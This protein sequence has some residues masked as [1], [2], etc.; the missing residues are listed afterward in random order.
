MATD[1]CMPPIWQD[2]NTD[3]K[4]YVFFKRFLPE[5]LFHRLLS[6]AHKNSMLEYPNGQPVLYRDAAMFWMRPS[7]DYK[8]A[9]RL[10]ILKEEGMIEVTISSSKYGMKPSD[11]LTQVFSM[12]DGIHKRDFPFVKFHCGPA[13]ISPECPG[14]RDYYKPHPVAQGNRHHIYDVMPGCQRD[15]MASL[16]CVNHS[17]EDELKEW[18]PLG[19][20]S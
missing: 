16:D 14:Y 9:Y 8:Q 5:P 1:G 20:I 3:K 19:S 17:F 13:C 2:D 11:V 18:V 4:F 10:R 15:K 7:Q 12:V 6:R